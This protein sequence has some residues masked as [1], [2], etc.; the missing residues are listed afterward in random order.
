MNFHKGFGRDCIVMRS[1]QYYVDLSGCCGEE[2]ANKMQSEMADI[3]VGAATWRTGQN[4]CVI[5]DSDQFIPLCEN[6]SSS[7]KLSGRLLEAQ[8]VERGK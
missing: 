5:F 3:A 8:H 2:N 4:I 1:S 6:M 7:A